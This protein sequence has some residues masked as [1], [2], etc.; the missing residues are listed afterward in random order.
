[1]FSHLHSHVWVV[2]GPRPQCLFHVLDLVLHTLFS[3]LLVAAQRPAAERK[4]IKGV[5]VVRLQ[6][7][8]NK[9]CPATVRGRH[10]LTCQFLQM[11]MKWGIVFIYSSFFFYLL[12]LQ[13]MLCLLNRIQLKLFILLSKVKVWPL[14]VNIKQLGVWYVKMALFYPKLFFFLSFFWG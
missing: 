8:Y 10:H 14:H 4:R 6:F 1:M 11:M 2:S 9:S 7:H 3:Q 13:W 12:L 5:F